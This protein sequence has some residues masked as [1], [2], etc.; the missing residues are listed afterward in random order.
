MKKHGLLLSI[1]L[2]FVLSFFIFCIAKSSA[3][4]KKNIYVDRLK[5]KESQL[6]KRQE[7]IKNKLIRIRKKLEKVRE[8][9]NNEQLYN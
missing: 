6:I 9:E 7:K 2:M 1:A 3:A 8:N 4:D 5:D